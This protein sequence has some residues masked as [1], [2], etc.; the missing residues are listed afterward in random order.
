MLL[1]D[2]LFMFCVQLK[3]GLFEQDLANRFQ[4]H[5]SPVC[6]KVIT[7]TN[8]FLGSQVIWPSREDV[9]SYMPEGF[10][11]FYASMRVILDCTEIFVQTPTSLLLQSQLHSTYKSNTT[12]KG[13]IGSTPYGTI[14]FV[15]SLYTG[16]ISDKGITRCSGILD[17]LEPGDSV[18]AEKGFDIEDLLREKGVEL[19]IPQFLESLEQI[20]AQDVQKTKTIACLRIHVERA[21][22]RVKGYHFFVLTIF[23]GNGASDSTFHSTQILWLRGDAGRQV[24]IDFDTFELEYSKDCKHDY[25]E[26]REASIEVGDPKTISG[27]NGPILTNRLCG[28]T[29]PNSIQSQGNMVWV[30]FMSDGNST[31]VY[32]GFRASFKAGQG[33]LSASCPLMLLFLSALIV[34]KVNLL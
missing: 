25:V 13:L 8:F 19:N 14:S 33:R 34:K 18:M 15:S 4:I 17:L 12:L 27:K 21:M 3:L 6:R 20:S 11:R 1:V 9:N 32:K 26:F 2:E 16:G 22:R 10:K 24:Q 29:K 28:N 5:R 31:T 30:Q 7:E 23:I